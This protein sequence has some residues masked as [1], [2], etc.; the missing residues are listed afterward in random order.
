MLRYGSASSSMA[1]RSLTRA[2][3]SSSSSSINT[4]LLLRAR[5]LHNTARRS[6]SGYPHSGTGS[7]AAAATGQP[8]VTSDRTRFQKL[9]L[10]GYPGYIKWPV[11]GL[12]SIVFS[13]VTITGGLL[14]WDAT[15]YRTAHLD[16]VP[17][18]PLAL[19]PSRGGSK[20]LKVAQFLVGDEETDEIKALEDKPK[21]VILGGGWG[22]VGALK[23]IPPGAYH[24]TLISDSTYNLFTP[25]LPAA[26]VGT[27]EPRSLV[28]PIRKIVAR[29]KGHFLNAK[30]V[31]IDMSE[32][33][34]EVS[35]PGNAENFYVPY[36]KLIISVGAVSNDHGVPGLENCYQLKTIDDSRKIRTHILDT[37]ETAGLPTTTPEE[38]DR[39][40]NFVVCGGGPTGIEFASELYDLISEDVMDYFPKL[41][42]QQAKVHVIQ[43]RDHILNTYSE[44]ISQYA[45]SKF[46]RNGVHTILNARVKEVG[47]NHVTYTTKGKDGKVEEV[48]IPCGF[49][50]WSTGIAMNPFTK[51]VASKLPNQYHKHALEV[52]S[53]LRVKGA[54]LGT[55][56]CIGDAST[57]ETNLTDH[58]WELLDMCD[59]NKDGRINFEE[60]EVMLKRIKRLFPT[61]QLHVEKVRSVFEKYDADKNGSIGVNELADMFAKISSRLTALPATA[62]VAEQ[63]GKYLGKKLAKLSASGHDAMQNMDIKDD[64]DDVLYEPFSYR[65]LGSLVYISNAAAFDFN[66]FNLAGGLAAMYLWRSVY[67]SEGVSYRQRLRLLI[68]WTLRGLFGRD[69]SKF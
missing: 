48:T 21:L 38:R 50:L 34:I 31:D 27:I 28:E 53:H 22:A 9:V 47:K 68:D 4:R 41:L 13:V 24:V 67:L 3:Q 37:F 43:S 61:S 16:R 69:L 58:L 7:T 32:R 62:Q 35:V 64:I 17:V 5:S 49:A 25:L 33:L 40:L 52:D 2:M 6:A 57:I 55:V 44:A 65:H 29:V 18:N 11:R 30:A 42:R 46:D 36:D 14:A 15:T 39:M 8:I 59:E 60:F 10:S 63:Q 56:Y 54:P 45:E 26:A 1:A 19:N 20:N 23:H 12:L 66:G 51:L